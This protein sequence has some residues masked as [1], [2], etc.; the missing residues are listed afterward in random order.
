MLV[1]VEPDVAGLDVVVPGDDVDDR[2]LAGT[3]RPDEPDLL[4]WLG[5]QRDVEQD[6]DAGDV[7]EVDVV[8]HHVAL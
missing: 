1:S 3:G 7:R 2:A 4:A 8:H 5:V 6:G